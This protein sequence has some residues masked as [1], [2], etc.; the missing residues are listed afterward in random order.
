M[1]K[2]PEK[3]MSEKW[4]EDVPDTAKYAIYGGGAAVGALLIS[5]LAFYCIK[6][7]R[8]GAAEARAAEQRNLADQAE[9]ARFK[10]E[11]IDPDAFTEKAQE[12]YAPG[13]KDDTVVTTEA[14]GAGP[15]HTRDLAGAGAGPGAGAGLAAGAGAAAAAAAGAMRSPV[16]LLRD[17]AQSPRVNSPG[18]MS[19]YHDS[20][21][22]PQ[23][24]RHSPGPG[25][26]AGPYRSQSPALPRSQSPAIRSQGPPQGNGY[27]PGPQSRNSPGPQRMQS[28]APM[29]QQRSFSDNHQSAYGANRMQTASPMNPNRS[30][31]SGQPP[32]RGPPPPQNRDYWNNGQY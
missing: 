19:P 23:S 2:E 32:Y 4:E 3:T 12:Y 13:M 21:R 16:P 17:G 22:S 14:Y 20:P 25:M 6:Q 26:N 31:S 30:F 5:G 24:A 28:P 1:H 8:R 11:G 27:G 15:N 7:R 10:K 18:P 29:G 9:H